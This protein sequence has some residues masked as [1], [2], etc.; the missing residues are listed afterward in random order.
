M[1]FRCV[2]AYREPVVSTIQGFFAWRTTRGTFNRLKFQRALIGS[3]LKHLNPWPLPR[4]IVV[5][6]NARIHMY[7]EF[8]TAVHS[9]GAVLLF[10]PPYCPQF[11]PIEVLFGQLK[12]WLARH[13]NLAFGLYPER[14]LEVAMPRCTKDE[15]GGGTGLFRHCGYDE[16]GLNE[17]VFKRELDLFQ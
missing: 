11:N 17:A 4:S 9:C 7:A 2:R 10:L 16:G 13:A 12:R 6:D 3:I 8:E 14:V 1:D 5:L 15:D